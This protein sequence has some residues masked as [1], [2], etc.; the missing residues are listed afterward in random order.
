MCAN[1]SSHDVN[2]VGDQEQDVGAIH[3]TKLEEMDE[4][5]RWADVNGVSCLGGN[6]LVYPDAFCAGGGTTLY[7]GSKSVFDANFPLLGDLG[8]R[9]IY[10]GDDPR[11]GAIWECRKMAPPTR[12][13]A[14]LSAK[15]CEQAVTA[16]VVM[17]WPARA[18]VRDG[19]RRNRQFYRCR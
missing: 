7:G 5:V 9:A 2:G 1:G 8:G 15:W 13:N 14:G 17:E 3:E 4:L 6:I 19:T 12:A 11:R 10:V 18:R 16:R